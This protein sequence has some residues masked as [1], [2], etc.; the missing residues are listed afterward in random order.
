MMEWVLNEGS[1]KEVKLTPKLKK[2]FSKQTGDAQ[3]SLL[4]EQLL[5]NIKVVEG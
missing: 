5:L 4:Q 3:Q 2:T 1:S